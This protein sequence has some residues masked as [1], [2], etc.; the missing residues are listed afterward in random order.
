[1]P[2]S[3]YPTIHERLIANSDEPDTGDGCWT[4]NGRKCRYGYGRFNIYYQGRNVTLSA[5]VAMHVI[6]VGGLLGVDEL[7]GAYKALQASGLEVDHT[8]VNSSCINPAHLEAVTQLEN[9]RRRDA[10]RW[11]LYQLQMVFPSA[12]LTA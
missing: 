6:R 1:M 7:M 8:C 2:R 10:R 5:H 9:T 4:W 11:G 12:T 3:P